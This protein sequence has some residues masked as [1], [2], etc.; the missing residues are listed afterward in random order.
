MV[1]GASVGPSRLTD[2]VMA[3]ILI[4]LMVTFRSRVYRL[5][6][7]LWGGMF[8]VVSRTK[9]STNRPR[10]AN[11]IVLISSVSIECS[12]NRLELFMS[13]RQATTSL[14]LETVHEL[15]PNRNPIVGWCS[16][17]VMSVNLSSVAS[18]VV[19]GGR[20]SMF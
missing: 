2:K 16:S 12:L 15:R 4:E 17:R 11:M 10:A 3:V 20:T 8:L 14:V 13:T 7:N 9:A 6:S 5:L 19:N 18:S 1:N